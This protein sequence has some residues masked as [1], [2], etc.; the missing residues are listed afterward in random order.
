LSQHAGGYRERLLLYPASQLADYASDLTQRRQ[1]THDAHHPL[2][3][4]Q[5]QVDLRAP[6]L[7]NL[8]PTAEVF[9]VVLENI[10]AAL[11]QSRAGAAHDVFAVQ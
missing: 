6:A 10:V 5:E 8:T 4:L 2:H 9:A 7:P 1:V 11:A 3:S